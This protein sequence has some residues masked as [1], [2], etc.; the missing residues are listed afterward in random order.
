MVALGKSYLD[1][2]QKRYLNQGY[3]KGNLISEHKGK[4]ILFPGRKV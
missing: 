3:Q 2:A 1:P 4:V